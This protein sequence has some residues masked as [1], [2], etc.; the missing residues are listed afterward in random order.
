MSIILVEAAGIR[1][2]G[3]K[4]WAKRIYT[5]CRDHYTDQH[6]GDFYPTVFV[7]F[8]TVRK[9]TRSVRYHGVD[10]GGCADGCTAGI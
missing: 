4:K 8:T 9:C 7:M 3:V 5:T 10:Q 1:A 6:S 2:K